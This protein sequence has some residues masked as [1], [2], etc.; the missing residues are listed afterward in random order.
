LLHAV[1]HSGKM[2]PRLSRHHYDLARLYWHEF[3]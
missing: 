1:F 2:S 3:G